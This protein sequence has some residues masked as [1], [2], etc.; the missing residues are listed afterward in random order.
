MRRHTRVLSPRSGVLSNQL[1]TYLARPGGPKVEL[2]TYLPLYSRYIRL[3]SL[4]KDQTP[5]PECRAAFYFWAFLTRERKC[6]SASRRGVVRLPGCGL[7]HGKPP[8]TK[9]NG[10]TLT[11]MH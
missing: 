2:P 9:G 10:H 7:G 3:R 11:Y 6:R 1:P 8:A 5:M 4:R